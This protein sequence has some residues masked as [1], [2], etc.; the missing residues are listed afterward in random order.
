MRPMSPVDSLRKWRPGATQ[1]SPGRRGA[2]PVSGTQARTLLRCPLPPLLL[3]VS[4]HTLLLAPISGRPVR[5]DDGDPGSCGVV[6]PDV[7]AP[8]GGT[9]AWL[10][11]D[12]GGPVLMDSI[13]I[14]AGS[15]GTPATARVAV[16]VNFFDVGDP[17]AAA[18][19][20]DDV[21][22][23][24]GAWAVS[25]CNITG[26]CVRDG[27]RCAGERGCA[28]R[29]ARFA[30]DVN[31]HIPSDP[32]PPPMQVR[33]SDTARCDH[34]G[35][36]VSS[37]DPIQRPRQ[38]QRNRHHR[39]RRQRQQR[40]RRRRRQ[41]PRRRCW[42]ALAASSGGGT[43]RCPRRRWATTAPERAARGWRQWR[44]A[45]PPAAPQTKAATPAAPLRARRRRRRRRRRAPSWVRTP[46]QQPALL[47]PPA[48]PAPRA[49][50]PAGRRSTPQT[51]PGC[52]SLG[53]VR[54]LWP[55]GWACCALSCG[56]AGPVASRTLGAP[57]PHAQLSM[58]PSR[59]PLLLKP[60][61]C[62]SSSLLSPPCC[63]SLPRRHNPA[64]SRGRG[65]VAEVWRAS[66]CRSASG[67][68]GSTT[69]VAG[70]ADGSGGATF[71]HAEL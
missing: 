11:L 49:A 6:Q 22:L 13:A 36:T 17:A 56:F 59:R 37:G 16:Y 44:P 62:A 40:R 46:S 1:R 29:T 47:A 71:R 31:T 53:T 24:P 7:A 67:G 63:R 35:G 2:L 64:G 14:L 28:A 20:C 9:A 50:W 25:A 68:G 69:L 55:A 12:E 15:S 54:M 60:P 30:A 33:P 10:T 58:S 27:W 42:R 19:A 61:P 4:S 52:P 21:V 26:R 5:I 3:H 39:C 41:R 66:Y 57:Q 23:Q 65:F 32:A 38:G 70:A 45:A 48:P 34:R 18:A 8:G 43:R 51:S